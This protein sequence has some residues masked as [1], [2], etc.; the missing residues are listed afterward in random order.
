MA[1]YK[2]ETIEGVRQLIKYHPQ[3][4]TAWFK[5]VF[6]RV[7]DVVASANQQDTDF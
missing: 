1:S 5:L 6:D 4:F 7:A 2:W 3:N